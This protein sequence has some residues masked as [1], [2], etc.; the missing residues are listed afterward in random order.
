M[1]NR[2]AGPEYECNLRK[3]MR[4][5]EIKW[6]MTIATSLQTLPHKHITVHGL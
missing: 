3:V 6:G 1:I 5:K 4:H 2:D